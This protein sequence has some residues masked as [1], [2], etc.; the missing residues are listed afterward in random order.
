MGIGEA[1]Q[2]IFRSVSEHEQIRLAGNVFLT[3]CYSLIRY[4][5]Y[6][7]LTSQYYKRGRIL[8]SSFKREGETRS[9]PA[10][11]RR[12]VG[13]CHERFLSFFLRSLY[14]LLSPIRL[15]YHLQT[16]TD[17]HD[18]WRGASLYTQSPLF[19]DSFVTHQMYQECG[20]AYLVE[21][22][23]SNS[24]PF[25]TGMGVASEGKKSVG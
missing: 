23:A 16:G 6:L 4:C 7:L 14:R 18:A 24:F 25:P 8:L 22:F 9:E 21:H 11:S 3:G 13:E 10:L 1:I 5:C 12:N 20:P 17:V 19:R 15:R 2:I